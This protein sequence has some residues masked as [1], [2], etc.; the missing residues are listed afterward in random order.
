MKVH[1]RRAVFLSCVLAVG[2]GGASS[3]SGPSTGAQAESDADTDG[4]TSDVSGGSSSADDGT[5]SESADETGTGETGAD[6]EPSTMFASE[7]I[8]WS[9]PISSASA[10]SIM[11]SCTG[12]DTGFDDL[13]GSSC[14]RWST[15]DIDGD[16]RLDLVSTW[17]TSNG[18]AVHGFGSSA[19]YWLVF[20]GTAT[21]FT[22][23]PI[24]W[25]VPIS[26]AS[27]EIVMG[28]CTGA[29]R[30]FDALSGSDCRRWST[31][32]IDGD[33]RLDL[34]SPWDST[35]DEVYGFGSEAH[36]WLVFLGT[37]TGFAAEPVEW[38]VPISSA[39][40]QIVM[41]GCV[42]ANSGFDSLAE[43]DCKRWS[44]LDL[45]GDGRLDLVSPWDHARN[46]V[47]GFGSSAH[48][49]LVFLGT[50]TG[51]ASEP[52]EWSVP[53]SSA[54]TQ[55]V[56]G[57]CVGADTGF[58]ELSGTDCK[59]WSTLDINGDGTLDLVSPWD[60]NGDYAVYGFGSEAHHW[61]VFLGNDT[62]FA[63]EPTEWSVPIS[64][65]SAE[66]I[67]GS[68]TGADA[69][70]DAVFG[71]YCK[72]WSTLDIDG[73]GRVD[74]VSPWDT[75]NGNAVH[76]FGSQEQYWMVFLGQ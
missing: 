72:R 20:L 32:D 44:T 8:R 28:G 67:M 71:S 73:D 1:T 30:G 53:I 27:A 18:N 10:E 40:T 15:L 3:D 29:D 6:V 7:P 74:L 13:F 16:G 4:D 46:E 24:E 39:S 61:R 47:H 66:S 75:S 17:D 57:G 62:G 54:S 38:S 41:G 52:I 14:K 49:W 60:T 51:F 42:G 55:I 36:Y 33:G 76:G 58:D 37:A 65:A 23:E 5:G 21:G 31:V 45:N 11:G 2:C 69:G 70:F 19:H 12:G 59:R 25:S 48:Y 43:A 64:S 35:T 22:S 9:V 63:S 34:V 50:D 26:G 56:M 68:C